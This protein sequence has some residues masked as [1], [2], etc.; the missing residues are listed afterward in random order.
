MN[1]GELHDVD[2]ALASMS[3]EERQAATRKFRKLSRKLG[4]GKKIKSRGGKRSAL[5][6][7]FWR[8]ISEEI[9]PKIDFDDSWPYLV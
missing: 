6:S 8:I 4:K 5:Y 1:R 3:P 7:A 2:M 9:D